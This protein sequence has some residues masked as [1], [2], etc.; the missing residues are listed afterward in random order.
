MTMRV[1]C[2]GCGRTYDVADELAGMEANCP[3]CGEV[4]AVP[5]MRPRAKPEGPHSQKPSEARRAASRRAGEGASRSVAA[6]TYAWGHLVKRGVALLVIVAL[7]VLAVAGLRKAWPKVAA[8]LKAGIAGLGSPSRIDWPPTTGYLDPPA[9][10]PQRPPEV[11]ATSSRFD[12]VDITDDGFVMGGRWEV[13]DGKLLCIYP[14]AT[15][16]Y[17]ARSPR[18]YE[19]YDYNSDKCWLKVGLTVQVDDYGQFVPVAY[20]PQAEPV[21]AKKGIMLAYALSKPYEFEP[22]AFDVLGRFT[23][24]TLDATG[25]RRSREALLSIPV[26]WT[27]SGD[28]YWLDPC[29][30]WAKPGDRLAVVGL[31]RKLDES[32]VE[33]ASRQSALSPEEITNSIDFVLKVV[34]AEGRAILERTQSGTDRG[35]RQTAK[36]RWVHFHWSR[37]V[38][39]SASIFGVAA[40]PGNQ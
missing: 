34:G 19:C 4:L 39:L 22:I 12:I 23:D 15:I 8:R 9:G 27:P 31:R 16:T 32:D 5:R 33:F 30:A 10:R 24:M 38:S 1:D 35:Q 40:P 13:V 3:R 6:G 17:L 18:R 2:P 28:A 20:D 25:L 14:G 36:G 26:L 7:V 29:P 11:V 21:K 37:P